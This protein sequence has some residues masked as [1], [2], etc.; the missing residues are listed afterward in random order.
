M[1]EMKSLSDW[2]RGG[3]WECVGLENKRTKDG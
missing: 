2:M 1:D 3:R